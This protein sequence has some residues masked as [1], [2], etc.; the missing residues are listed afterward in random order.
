ME[1]DQV[2]DS[3]LKDTELSTE[4]AALASSYLV[5]FGSGGSDALEKSSTATVATTVTPQNEEKSTPS[6]ELTLDSD[7]ML[8]GEAPLSAKM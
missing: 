2:L 4:E 5:E 8:G 7:G 3:S 6:I 1:V